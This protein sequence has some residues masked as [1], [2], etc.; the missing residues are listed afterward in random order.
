MVGV[1][2]VGVVMEPV[3]TSGVTPDRRSCDLWMTADAPTDDEKPAQ[4]VR[5]RQASRNLTRAPTRRIPPS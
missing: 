4:I 3:W 1:V 2:M 5:L